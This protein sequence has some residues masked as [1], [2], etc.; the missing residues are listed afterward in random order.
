LSAVLAIVARVEHKRIKERTVA[1]RRRRIVGDAVKGKPARLM[2]GSLPRYGWRYAD[3]E[4]SR[5]V[6]HPDAAAVMARV[7]RE[8]GEDGRSLNAIC[9]D[10]EAEGILPPTEALAR[11]GYKIG[12]RKTSMQWNAPSLGRMLHNPA[13]WG[14]AIAYRYEGYKHAVRDKETH[15]I[16]RVKR[17]RLRDT[18]SEA[19]RAAI[20]RYPAEVWPGIVSKEL[21]MKALARLE[22]NKLE[23]QRNLKH[24]DTSFLRAGLVVCG[25]C[26]A[27]LRLR[28]YKQSPDA[29]AVLR[30]GC[31]R[32]ENFKLRRV[33]QDGDT[34][35][36]P[37]H[38]QVHLRADV[39]EAAVWERLAALLADPNRVPAAYDALKAREDATRAQLARRTKTLTD[40]IADAKQRRLRLVDMAAG[41]ADG[42]VRAV[43]QGKIASETASIRTWEAECDKL[44][45]EATAQA[46]DTQEVRDV[47]DMFMER[48]LSMMQASTAQRRRLATALHLRVAVYTTNHAPWIEM[49]CD[50]PGIAATWHA[51]TLASLR[52]QGKEGH[53]KQLAL[54][55]GWNRDAWGYPL[56][57]F[58]TRSGKLLFPVR[59][60]AD[61][62]QVSERVLRQ[63]TPSRTG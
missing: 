53:M 44:E 40:L 35:D 6:L 30:F 3:A 36:C 21:A 19:G 13:Y 14:E 58:D 59:D 17:T 31:G 52:A 29:E 51:E 61:P 43:Y 56:P 23:A 46:A 39:L 16:R 1:G 34:G 54:G 49:A 57:D 55:L 5:Y 62:P 8:V 27:N 18:E 25:Y 38:G 33:A 60:T 24:V 63:A 15:R 26:G 45:S 9:V 7:Y 50:L 32:H 41:E 48:L 20:V 4:K 47:M 10:L 42:E 22:Q 12:R 37:A 2:P 28:N 11:E